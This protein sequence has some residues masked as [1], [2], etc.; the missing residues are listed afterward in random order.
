M[1]N[2]LEDKIDALIAK[3]WEELRNAA[4]SKD[5]SALNSLNGRMAELNKM[6]KDLQ[7]I[8]VRVYEMDDS[9]KTVQIKNPTRLRKIS[10]RVTQGMLNQNLLTLTD[11]CRQGIVH[12]G[13]TF[14]I[15][16]LPNNGK[17]NTTLL[18]AGNRLKQRGKIAAFYQAA[19][20]KPGDNVEMTEI[21]PGSWQ[22]KAADRAD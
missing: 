3:A 17:I 21:S 2:E 20:V 7:L 1:K 15:E 9:G 11:A 4:N 16:T 6:K 13:E 5:S 12:R 19:N 10:I 22:L 18:R 14:Q 8:S